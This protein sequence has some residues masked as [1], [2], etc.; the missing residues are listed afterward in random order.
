MSNMSYCRF[1]NTVSDLKDCDGALEEF[2]GSDWGPLSREE[3][4]AA[5]NLVEVCQTILQRVT[6]AM[7]NRD[8]EVEDAPDIDLQ[9]VADVMKDQN[10][11]LEIAAKGGDEYGDE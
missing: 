4:R 7:Q 6:E 8:V 11:V 9:D 3:L 10:E 5:V 2:F 1:Q